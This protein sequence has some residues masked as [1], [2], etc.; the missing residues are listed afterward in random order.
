MAYT[1]KSHRSNVSL[2]NCALTD[3][4]KSV[5]IDTIYL[6]YLCYVYTLQS[7]LQNT[8]LWKKKIFIQANMPKMYK[9]KRK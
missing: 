7:E 2:C 5:Q 3:F 6:Y 4:V 1:E 9:E 8:I